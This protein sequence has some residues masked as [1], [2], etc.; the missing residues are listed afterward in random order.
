MGSSGPIDFWHATA[1][2]DP[3]HLVELAKACEEAGFAG[4]LVSDHVVHPETIRS[5]YPYQPDGVPY[6]NAET[7]WID[8]WVAIGAMAAVTRRLRFSQN[9]YLLPVR[10]PIEVAKVAAS[11][12]VLSEG[13]V[14]LGVG[15]GWMAEEHAILGSDFSTRGARTDEAIEICRKLWRGGPVAHTGQHHA[16]PPLSICPTPPGGH[17]PVLV[18][19]E[20]DAALRRAARNDGWIGTAYKSADARAILDRLGTHLRAAGRQLGDGYE[21]LLGLYSLKPE[22]FREFADAGV[23]G[24]LAAP[25]MLAGFAAEARGATA[26]LD[27]RLQAVAEFG[28]TTIAPLRQHATQI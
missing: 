24:F 26:T 22:A 10:H 23:T 2:I 16:F 25:A 15:I 21:V 12:A 6:W 27:E 28:E 9:V 14:S 19:G 11:A 3:T 4:I 1:F 13:R 20:S 17:I 18:G 8:P 5:A 7:P